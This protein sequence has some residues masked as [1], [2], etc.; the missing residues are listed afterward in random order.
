MK[1]YAVA[2]ISFSDNEIELNIV[3]TEGNW[4]DALN[5]AYPGGFDFKTEDIKEAQKEAFDGDCM[6]NVKEITI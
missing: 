2:F 4:K 6:F 5:L 3:E 1:R